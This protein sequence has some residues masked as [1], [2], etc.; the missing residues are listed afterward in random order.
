MLLFFAY[1]S[2][3]TAQRHELGVFVGAANYNGELNPGPLNLNFL[4]PGFGVM[5]RYNKNKFVSYKLEAFYGWVS[6]D[7]AKSKDSF[8]IQRNLSFFSH[9]LDFSGEVEFNFFPFIPG[10]QEIYFT[11]YIFAGFTIF[12]FNPTANLGD[13]NYALEPLHTEG[14]GYS[15]VAAALPFGGGFKMSVTQIINIGF[16]LGVRRTY[17]GYLDDVNGVYPD[18]KVFAG[19]PAAAALSNRSNIPSEVL[20][21]KQRGNQSGED[22]YMFAGF[23]ITFNVFNIGK[24]S[25]EAFPHFRY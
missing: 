23:W 3:M 2:T 21:G 5:Y 4:H 11:P 18:P 17:T 6:G 20:V 7:D 8:Q 9:V 10:T 16:E 15:R 14:G 13:T 12:Q 24:H 22:W 19:N 25:C 1:V